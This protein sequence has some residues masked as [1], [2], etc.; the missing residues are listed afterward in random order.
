MT[1]PEDLDEDLFA[2]LYDGDDN[3]PPPAAHAPEAVQADPGP[4]DTTTT[5]ITDPLYEVKPAI[6]QEEQ[7]GA[8]AEEQQQQMFDSGTTGGDSAGWDNGHSNGYGNEIDEHE[9]HGTGIKED[10]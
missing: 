7:Y 5:N 6:S 2:D 3:G 9:A 4:S 10:G 1:E 8:G